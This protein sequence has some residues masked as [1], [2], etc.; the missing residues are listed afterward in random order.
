MGSL[1]LFVLCC[2]IQSVLIV[3]CFCFSFF[4]FRLFVL[5]TAHQ[6]PLCLHCLSLC[7]AILSFSLPFLFTLFVTLSAVTVYVVMSDFLHCH[8]GLFM[9]SRWTF[10]IVALEFF[11]CHDGLVMCRVGL[12]TSSRWTFYIVALEFLCCHVGTFT[13]SPW[14]FYVVSLKCLHCDDGLFVLSRCICLAIPRWRY[15]KVRKKTSAAMQNNAAAE[16]RR[17]GRGAD[18]GEN[19]LWRVAM[20]RICRDEWRWGESVVAGG[21]GENLSWRV[22][23]GRVCRGGWR[24][25]VRNAGLFLPMA[26]GR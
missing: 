13:L 5:S 15:Y 16:S 21:G 17:V 2:L 1:F 20:R 18:S 23:M 12:F 3:F 14:N 24:I 8:V 9:L 6:S 22:A 10:Y 4:L 7:P 25:T 26:A 19:L 11:C